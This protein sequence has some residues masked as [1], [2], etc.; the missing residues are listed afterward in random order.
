MKE[1]WCVNWKELDIYR[2]EKPKIDT[3][4]SQGIQTFAVFLTEVRGANK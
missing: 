3:R 4:K 2:M 1:L